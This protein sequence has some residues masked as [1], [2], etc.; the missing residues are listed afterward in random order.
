MLVILGMR[1]YYYIAF[2]T[3]ETA[4][5][6]FI[7]IYIISSSHPKNLKA[8]LIHHTSLAIMI[9]ILLGVQL[10]HQARLLASSSVCV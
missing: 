10:I 3:K 1:S 5:K 6:V 9:S 2:P 8:H 7:F 4:E